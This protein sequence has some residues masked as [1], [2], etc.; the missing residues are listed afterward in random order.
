MGK[1]GEEVEGKRWLALLSM[2]KVYKAIDDK[3]LVDLT[4]K[5]HRNMWNA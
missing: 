4:R 2:E 5:Q 3:D 1:Y